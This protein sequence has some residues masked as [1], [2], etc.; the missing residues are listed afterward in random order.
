M[1]LTVLRPACLLLSTVLYCAVLYCTVSYSHSRLT[2]R[3]T[4]DETTLHNSH[5]APFKVQGSVFAVAR[6]A[7]DQT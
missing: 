5:A 7:G 3:R 6:S 4:V 2:D 1:T